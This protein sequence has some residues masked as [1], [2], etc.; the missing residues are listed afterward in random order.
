MDENVGTIVTTDEAIAFGV[1]KPLHSTFQSIHLLS[2]SVRAEGIRGESPTRSKL[3]MERTEPRGHRKGQW[4][5]SE[6][7][8]LLFSAM[9]NVLSR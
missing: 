8:V 3:P 4:G 1:V 9:G 7:G 5:I 2:S 6:V